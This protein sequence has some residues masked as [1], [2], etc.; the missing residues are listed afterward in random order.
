MEFLEDFCLPVA[1]MGPRDWAPFLREASAWA[2]EAVRLGLG[3]RASM[4][5]IFLR[6]MAEVVSISLNF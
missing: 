6:F 2:G 1:E 3:L 5:E 4:G